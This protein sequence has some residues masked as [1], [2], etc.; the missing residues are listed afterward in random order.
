[1]KLLLVAN[2]NT[3]NSTRERMEDDTSRYRGAI[4]SAELD[5]RGI[6]WIGRRF[7]LWRMTTQ[8]KG[9]NCAAKPNYGAVRSS[10]IHFSMTNTTTSNGW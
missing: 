4:F 1:M 5:Q 3:R 7:S 6:S 9:P 2:Q 10:G 8:Q